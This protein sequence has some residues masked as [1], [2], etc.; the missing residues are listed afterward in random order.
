M[1]TLTEAQAAQIARKQR[2]P[3]PEVEHEVLTASERQ[4]LPLEERMRL[5]EERIAKAQANLGPE[6]AS[7]RQARLFAGLATRDQR[8][9]DEERAARKERIA[10]RRQERLDR[11][12]E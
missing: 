12:A 3:K 1:K 2:D 8:E 4:M 9:E 10:A 7:E 5:R 6:A 11:E